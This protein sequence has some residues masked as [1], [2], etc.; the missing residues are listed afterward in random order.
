MG[1]KIA[2]AGRRRT[3]LYFFSSRRLLLKCERKRATASG[4]FRGA[5]LL[6]RAGTKPGG[7]RAPAGDR[8]AGAGLGSPRRR[9]GQREER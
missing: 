9:T 1:I 7:P 2:P 5:P 4:G 6:N 8:R 3:R